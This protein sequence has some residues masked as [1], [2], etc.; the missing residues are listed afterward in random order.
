M[1]KLCLIILAVAFVSITASALMSNSRYVE[2][3]ANARWI[4]LVAGFLAVLAV[5]PLRR[6]LPIWA[7]YFIVVP[8]VIG[9]WMPVLLI[10][11][12]TGPGSLYKACNNHL[13]QIVSALYTYRQDNQGY[14]P[15]DDRG[16]L[17]SLALLYPRYLEDPRVLTCPSVL[18][19]W[20]RRHEGATFPRETS[21]AG[22]KCHF[23]YTW[24][25]PANPPPGFGVAADMPQNH[26]KGFNVAY[27]DGSVFWRETPFCSHDP[28]DNIFA[29]EPGW[30]PDTD[31]YIRQIP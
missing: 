22:V 20:K 13:G 31:S 14:L 7:F 11:G 25:V 8:V 17:H 27:P 21:L 15:F 18:S 9:F 10:L 23:G 3:R 30:S 16:P 1:R 24:H 6:T 29:P 12:R 4:A 19:R 2:F 5:L 28:A 26:V